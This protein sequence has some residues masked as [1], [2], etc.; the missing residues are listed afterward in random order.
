LARK[1]DFLFDPF[2]IA[3]V[4]KADLDKSIVTQALA[5]VRDYVLEAVLSDTADQRSAVT[6]RAFPRLNPN[7]A[8]QKK[9]AG[10]KPIPNLEFDGDMLSS[11]QVIPA[12]AGRLKL[13]VSPDQADK[14]DGH[15][16]HSGES[17][18]IWGD[19]EFQPSGSCGDDLQGTKHVAIE[20]EVGDGLMS[21]RLLLLRVIGVQSRERTARH[22]ATLV[23]GITEHG[24]Q[25]IVTHVR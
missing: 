2:E 22:R 25:D 10:H 23:G 21:G 4:N 20:F 17:R 3:G 12:A 9:A 13:T 1:V 6:G 16:N 5:D 8:K 14:A 11:L 15:N 19:R 24:L 7:Y 18:L